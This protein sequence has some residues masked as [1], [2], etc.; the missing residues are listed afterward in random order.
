ML[1]SAPD[2]PN[3]RAIMVEEKPSPINPLGIK[4]A[5]EGGV[6]PMG[7]LMSNAVA[8]A[9]SSLGVEPKALPLSPAN[10]W[11]LIEESRRRDATA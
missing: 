6:L 1:P 2:F 11:K 8:S 9:L 7:G 3:F 5:G 10:L 4:G